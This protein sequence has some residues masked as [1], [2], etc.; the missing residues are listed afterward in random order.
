VNNP[1]IEKEEHYY[2]PTFT[3]LL[4]LG[5]KPN[6]LT[7]EVLEAMLKSVEQYKDKVNKDAIFIGVKW[8]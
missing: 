1:R 2:N 8:K 4:G 5:L 7:D 3:K 6:Y